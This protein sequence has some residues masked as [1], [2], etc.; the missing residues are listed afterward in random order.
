MNCRASLQARWFSGP[1]YCAELVALLLC[2]HEAKAAPPSPAIERCEALGAETVTALRDLPPS[3]I[4]E[5]DRQFGGGG[6][7]KYVALADRDQD[8]QPTDVIMDATL[9]TRRFIQAGHVGSRWYVWYEQGGIAHSFH[10]A[11][12]DVKPSDPPVVLG[13]DFAGPAGLC[14]TT[15]KIWN[16]APGPLPNGR[17]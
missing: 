2:S 15:R 4:A 14:A 10:V 5:L 7:G 17:M 3:L 6:G 13:L 1:L 11:L 12:F 16:L 8:W 9:P